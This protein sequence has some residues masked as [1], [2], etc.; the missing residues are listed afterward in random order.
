MTYAYLVPFSDGRRGGANLS[1]RVIVLPDSEH[2]QT[3]T[4]HMPWVTDHTRTEKI[5][6]DSIVF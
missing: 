6:G 3:R 5:G 1:S 2:I 4:E